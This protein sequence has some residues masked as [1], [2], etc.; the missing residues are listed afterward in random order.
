MDWPLILA[1]AIVAAIAAGVIGWIRAARDRAYQMCR[2][3]HMRMTHDHMRRGN[4]CGAFVSASGRF[5]GCACYR[6]RPRHLRAW[7]VYWVRWYGRRLGDVWLRIHPPRAVAEARSTAERMAAAIDRQLDIHRAAAARY[8]HD[9]PFGMIETVTISDQAGNRIA[10]PIPTQ[11]L[12][13][14]EECADHFGGP[15]RMHS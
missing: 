15:L 10:G 11:R 4:D 9:A 12:C 2:C 6:R 14:D 3:G 7:I 8:P 13:L 5:C 1:G